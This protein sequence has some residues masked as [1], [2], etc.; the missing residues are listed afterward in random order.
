MP[1]NVSL[2]L[3]RV[4]PPPSRSEAVLG[5]PAVMKPSDDPTAVTFDP[6]SEDALGSELDWRSVEL[7]LRTIPGLMAQPGTEVRSQRRAGA[8]VAIARRGKAA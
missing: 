8:R 3:E 5:G 7:D 6:N 2:A 1:K 4:A